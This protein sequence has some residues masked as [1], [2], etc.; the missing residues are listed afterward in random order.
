[1][2]QLVDFGACLAPVM[3]AYASYQHSQQSTEKEI[4][5]TACVSGWADR[6]H[7]YLTQAAFGIRS[8]ELGDYGEGK[9]P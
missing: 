4:P 1:M 7:S 2:V 3:P 5:S 9:T 8:P 6:V